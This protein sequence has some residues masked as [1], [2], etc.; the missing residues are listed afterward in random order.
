MIPT[1]VRAMTV[2]VEQVAIEVAVTLTV[3]AVVGFVSELMS[4]SDG[5]VGH[6]RCRACRRQLRGS[7]TTTG[8]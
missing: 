8:G 3:G 6:A 2:F 5:D 4:G 7:I 1:G